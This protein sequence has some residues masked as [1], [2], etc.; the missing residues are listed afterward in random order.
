MSIS[1]D[2]YTNITSNTGTSF[3][4]SHTCSGNARVLIVSFSHRTNDDC[5]GVTYNGVAMTQLKKINV[6]DG[7][8]WI[9]MYGLIGPATGAHNV[10][11]NFT[12]SQVNYYTSVSYNGCK[13]DGLPN[14]SYSASPNTNQTSITGTFTTTKDK[15][16]AVALV[17]D[18]G[19]SE[20]AGTGAT[21]IHST[22][23]ITLAQ[24]N[25]LTITPAGSFS[26]TI[27]HSNE[28]DAI[29]M[30]GI[31]PAPEFSLSDIITMTEANSIWK[32][33]FTVR[34]TIT[35]SEPFMK[36]INGWHNISKVIS[37]WSNQ[38]K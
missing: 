37:S 8:E 23:G 18:N 21:I 27:N 6:P 35:G 19:G 29:L 2:T 16:I 7:N 25:P 31:E 10:V 9:Y 30:V 4:F 15:C 34:D 13:Q 3:T 17:F 11:A 20:T 26:L 28:T 14:V 36:I 38:D 22:N 24:S 1:R 33:Y 5:T 12:T 32:F